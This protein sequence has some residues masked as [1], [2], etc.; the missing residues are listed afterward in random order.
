MAET[1]G[2]FDPLRKKV[3]AATPEESVRQSVIRWL[4]ESCGI[5]LVRMQSE[6]GFTYNGRQ[7]RADIVVFDRNLNPEIL[8]ECKAPSVKLDDN[9]IEQVTRYSRVLMARKIMITNG[10]ESLYFFF[11]GTAYIQSETL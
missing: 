11:D 8:V 1:A 7:Y 4:S 9:V 6:W 3:V 5:P 10:N 2:Y